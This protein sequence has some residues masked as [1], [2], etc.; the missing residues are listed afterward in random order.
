MRAFHE[1]P[2]ST[3]SGILTNENIMDLTALPDHLIVLGGGYVGLEFG[4]MYRRF[5]SGVTLIHNTNQ[6]VPQ[7]GPGGLPL[8]CKKFLR[9]R[10]LRFKC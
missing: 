4:Q 6:I 1:F 7:G 2:A 10:E 8:N 3:P 5:G 9:P